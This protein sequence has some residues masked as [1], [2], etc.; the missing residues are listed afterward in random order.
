MECAMEKKNTKRKTEKNNPKTKK[1]IIFAPRKKRSQAMTDVS[2]PLLEEEFHYYLQNQD[3]L[4]K[5]FDGRYL[6]IV[7]Q[8][9]VGDYDSFSEAVVEA[10][11][12]HAL[13]TFL[14]Q[15][16]SEGKEDYS[17]T[18]HSHFLVPNSIC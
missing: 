7:G 17:I 14:V 10:Q 8:Q 11:K 5:Q 12:E 9:V 1:V 6:V 16:C 13:G 3:E 15:R 18:Y 2:K 4:V